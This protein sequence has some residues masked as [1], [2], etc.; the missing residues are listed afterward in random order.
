MEVSKGVG[1]GIFIFVFGM[2]T[3]LGSKIIGRVNTILFVAM[4]AAYVALVGMGLDE[5]NLLLLRHEN[6]PV[7]LMAMPFLLTSFSF[8]TMVPSLT[9]YLHRHVRSMRWA[10]IGGTTVAFLVYLIWQTLLLGIVPAHG[11]MGLVEAFN[12]GESPIQFLAEHVHGSALSVFAGFFAFFALVTSFLGITM[13]L[14]DFLSDGLQIPEKGAGQ[15]FLGAIVII[16]TLFFA[17]YFERMFLLALDT[18]GGFGDSILNG[19]IPVLMVWTGRYYYG[20]KGPYEVP[21]GKWLLCG[22]FIF[23]AFTLVIEVLSKFNALPL[24]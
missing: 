24:P 16:P 12:K 23:F 9:P 11:E 5:V 7:T 1:C 10:I 3:Y 19:I 21:G 4:M 22:V 14:F 2:V 13:G 8:Q 6:W 17:I 18:S 15:I 20:F